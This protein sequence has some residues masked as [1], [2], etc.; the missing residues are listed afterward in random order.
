MG[1]AE[2]R[3]NGQSLARLTWRAARALV[4]RRV[5]TMVVVCAA[6]SLVV[7]SLISAV[8]MAP[9]GVGMMEVSI[10]AAATRGT[11]LAAIAVA[12]SKATAIT[13]AAPTPASASVRAATASTTATY[14]HLLMI[15]LITSATNA[16]S[17]ALLLFV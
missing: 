14:S 16:S 11:A 3:M 7:P 2:V 5:M 8:R 17:Y 1:V 4:R 13:I 15:M 10:V 9:L 12:A 6:S